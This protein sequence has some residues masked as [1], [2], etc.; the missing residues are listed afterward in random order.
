MEKH[1]VEE[2]EAKVNAKR[3]VLE[4]EK[5]E[6]E[7]KSNEVA[8]A[9]RKSRENKDSNSAVIERLQAAVARARPGVRAAAPGTS[10]PPE[11]P[12]MFDG[13]LRNRQIPKN[14]S[15]AGPA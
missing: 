7:K 3:A 1:R 13:I 6:E 5:A 2:D 15:P 14:R 4:Q 12:P 11:L 9:E 8:E 10:Q